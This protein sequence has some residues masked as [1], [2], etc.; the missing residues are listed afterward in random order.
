MKTKLAVP[1]AAR[2]LGHAEKQVAAAIFAGAE[3]S[4]LQWQLGN[5]DEVVWKRDLSV[6]RPWLHSPGVQEWYAR[7]AIEFT[8]EF[9]TLVEREAQTRTSAA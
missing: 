8:P 2:D 5:L 6:L 3:V 1:I 4:L 7:S 9:R